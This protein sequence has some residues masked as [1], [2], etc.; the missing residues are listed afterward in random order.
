MFTDAERRIFQFED[1][2]RDETG[3]T[4]P[5]YADPYEVQAAMSAGTGGDLDG[6]IARSKEFDDAGE[7]VNPPEVAFE[8]LVKLVLAIRRAF[9]LLPFE[10]IS[11]RGTTVAM[12]ISIWNSFV[13][14][15]SAQ[16]KT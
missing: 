8:N 11:G 16:K 9:G 5:V 12:C 3:D 2:S 4:Y 13:A 6:V 7:R 15:Q 1:G 14:F 10:R